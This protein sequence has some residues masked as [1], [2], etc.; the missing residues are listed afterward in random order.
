MGRPSTRPRRAPRAGA[1]LRRRPRPTSRV[2]PRLARIGEGGGAAKR[3]PRTARERREVAR[4]ARRAGCLIGLSQSF[5][6]RRVDGRRRGLALARCERPGRENATGSKSRMAGTSPA[7]TRRGSRGQEA[8]ISPRLSRRV[9]SAQRRS[10]V[11]ET[12]SR[13]ALPRLAG[14]GVTR[15]VTDG[16]WEGGAAPGQSRLSLAFASCFPHPIRPA[17][18]ATFPSFAGEGRAPSRL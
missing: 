2:F 15:S 18:P 8:L 11:R 9:G 4:A 16:V 10:T 12:L 3:A 14:E 13:R 6:S 17:S 1:G 5:A 7:M